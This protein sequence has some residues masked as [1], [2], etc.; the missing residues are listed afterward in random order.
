[1]VAGMRIDTGYLG[2]GV[3][4]VAAGAIALAIENG[5]VVDQR[6]WTY[7]PLLLIGAG[8]GLILRRTPFEAIGGLVVAATFG[9]MVGGSLASGFGGIGDMTG[10]VCQI[11]DEGTAFADRTGQFSGSASV[12]VELDCGT[13]TVAT[14][15]GSGWAVR[16]TDRRTGPRRQRQRRRARRPAG[17]RS[18]A[19]RL[20]ID[21]PTEPLLD[22]GL[23]LNAGQLRAELGRRPAGG[24]RHGGQR[25]PGRPRPDRGRRHRGHRHRGQRR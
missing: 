10:G 5:D 6:W 25:R 14:A 3:F 9:V 8:I 16:G 2:W 12:D 11:G 18:L 23:Q 20:A 13:V 1:M 22:V 7:W 4:F 17:R 24:G 21:L 19:V 15:P